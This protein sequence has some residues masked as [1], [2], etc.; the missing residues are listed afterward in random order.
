MPAQ[1]INNTESW[2]I[3]VSQ[4]FYQDLLKVILAPF[5]IAVPFIWA[6][7]EVF[8]LF[9]LSFWMA[10]FVGV[11]WIWLSHFIWFFPV[12]FCD[13][14][15]LEMD[16]KRAWRG[17]RRTL[18]TTQPVLPVD[19]RP[20]SPTGRIPKNPGPPILF[21][22]QPCSLRYL[23]QAMRYSQTLQVLFRLTLRKGVPAVYRIPISLKHTKSIS[24][25]SN[26]SWLDSYWASGTLRSQIMSP[27]KTGSEDLEVFLTD[28]Y[29]TAYAVMDRI[30]SQTRQISWPRSCNCF[31]SEVAIKAR[32]VYY[33]T[34]FFFHSLF[35][36][37]LQS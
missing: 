6:L 21:S 13:R 11:G 37:T 34:V 9:V 33:T 32:G 25:S 23:L 14:S 36:K 10:S 18:S 7:P 31:M 35:S 3:E 24:Q 15:E 8:I 16:S 1:S 17:G 20:A 27:V 5:W 19:Q 28:F 12:C 30:P 29:I 26:N 2:E 22:F 4:Q